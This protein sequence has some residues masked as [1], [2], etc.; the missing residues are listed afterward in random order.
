MEPIDYSLELCEMCKFTYGF[1][2]YG[3]LQACLRVANSN[4]RILQKWV[5]MEFEGNKNNQQ[6]KLSASTP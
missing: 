1:H 4:F 2:T 3:D 5:M 6:V